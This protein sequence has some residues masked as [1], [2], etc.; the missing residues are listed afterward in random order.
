MTTIFD[1]DEPFNPPPSDIPLEDPVQPAVGDCWCK[2]QYANV[3]SETLGRVDVTDV[4]HIGGVNVVKFVPRSGG[5]AGK[6]VMVPVT[7][8]QQDYVPRALVERQ[9]GV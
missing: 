3:G 1:D 4:Q 6:V 5:Q 9:R 7:L 2:R 8:F